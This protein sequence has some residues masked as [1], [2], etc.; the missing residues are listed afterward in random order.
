MKKPN[1]NNYSILNSEL[2][3]VINTLHLLF[4]GGDFVKRRTSSLKGMRGETFLGCFMKELFQGCL[5]KEGRE[6]IS[7][8]STKFQFFEN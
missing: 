3:T 8:Y 2:S 4:Y 5:N 6:R 7:I 1:I